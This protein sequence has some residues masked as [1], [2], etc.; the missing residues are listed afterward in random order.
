MVETT[1]HPPWVADLDEL[2]TPL[3]QRILDLPVVANAAIDSLDNEAAQNFCVDFYPLIRD[4]PGWLEVLLKRSPPEGQRFFR[5]N[6]RVERRHDA[7]WRAMGDGFGVPEERFDQVATPI[8]AVQ[9]FHD[10]LTEIG[11][12][13]PFASAVAATNYAVEGVAQ[14]IAS[15]ALWGLRHNRQL[16]PRGRWWLEEHAK[17]D[18]EHPKQALEVIKICVS[19]GEDEIESIKQAASR[20]LELM[21]AAMVESYHN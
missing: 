11:A 5:D 18:D 9:E 13:G 14:K 8:T 17:Y 1:L 2:L 15:R 4:F 7:L 16:G 10:F 6:M 20:S 3:E 21:Y 12:N 19:R